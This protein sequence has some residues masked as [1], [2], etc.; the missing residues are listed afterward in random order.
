MSANGMTTQLLDRYIE[1]ASPVHRLDARVK[2][3]LAV[4]FILSA[5]LLPVGS[6]L[7]LG[8]DP[9]LGRRAG[10]PA[11][12]IA[13]GAAVSGG[14]GDDHLQRAGPAGLLDSAWLRDLDR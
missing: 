1:G 13:A 2:L 5:S 3:V 10:P 11:A 4:A 14:C 8:G 9:G 12:T 6:W 7:A